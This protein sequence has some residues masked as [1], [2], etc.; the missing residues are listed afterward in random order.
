MANVTILN[1]EVLALIDKVSVNF[2][3]NNTKF[4]KITSNSYWK[5]HDVAKIKY[6]VSSFIKLNEKR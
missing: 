6:E 1:H 2:R 5:K 3:I 4:S